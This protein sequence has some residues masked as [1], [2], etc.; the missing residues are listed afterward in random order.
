MFANLRGAITYTIFAQDW[1]RAYLVSFQR[2]P[3]SK[4]VD[5][6]RINAVTRNLPE[7]LQK[8]IHSIMTRSRTIDIYTDSRH[9]RITYNDNEITGYG[10]RG[11]SFLRRGK[12]PI[13]KPAVHLVDA[14]GNFR[15]PNLHP[16]YASETLTAVHDFDD[17]YPTLVTIQGPTITTKPTINAESLYQFLTSKDF[18]VP[19][20]K[21]SFGLP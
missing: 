9:R 3:Q 1:I 14:L 8:L 20:E 18:C 6:R 12:R 5:V 2:A 19:T 15:R 16:S 17:A 21:T 4:N 7:P 10:L 11:M 13:G